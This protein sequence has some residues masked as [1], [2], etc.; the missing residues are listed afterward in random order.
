MHPRKRSAKVYR[1]AVLDMAP[2]D[3]NAP[4]QKA[5]SEELRQRGY[6]EGEN[7]NV[8]RRNANRSARPVA[9]ARQRA[10]RAST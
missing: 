2:P 7:L 4:N 1:I 8:E 10:G 5:F 3:L 6:I 9:S